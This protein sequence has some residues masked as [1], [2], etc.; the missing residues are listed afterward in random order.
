VGAEVDHQVVKDHRIW[1]PALDKI[2]VPARVID[3]VA[4][5]LGTAC[6]CEATR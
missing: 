5:W 3:A 2:L 1:Q 4:R 6:V